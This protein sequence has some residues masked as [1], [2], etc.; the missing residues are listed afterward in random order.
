M[1]LIK[2]RLEKLVAMQADLNQDSSSDGE[3][4]DSSEGPRHDVISSYLKKS[5]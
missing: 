1:D 4:I 2:S 3:V 5:I